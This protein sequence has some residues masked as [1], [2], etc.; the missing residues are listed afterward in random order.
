[1]D[2]EVKTKIFSIINKLYISFCIV[3]LG[4]F[5]IVSYDQVSL[6]FKKKEFWIRA[7]EYLEFHGKYNPKSGSLTLDEAR[8]LIGLESNKREVKEISDFVDADLHKTPKGHKPPLNPTHYLIDSTCFDSSGYATGKVGSAF[9]SDCTTVSELSQGN[10]LKA[11]L[12]YVGLFLGLIVVMFLARKWV[13][14][15]V[16]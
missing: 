6:E 12:Q 11:I 13:L 3:L 15:L 14:W 9:Y 1:M 5:V 8:E 10:L 4:L 2:K 16:K 7:H